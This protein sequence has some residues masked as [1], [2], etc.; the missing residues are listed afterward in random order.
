VRR[1]EAG[2]KSDRDFKSGKN[3]SR[4]ENSGA[5]FERGLARKE[6]DANY[7]QDGDLDSD[8]HKPMEEIADFSLPWLQLAL[9]IC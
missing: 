6:R 1:R 3:M 4:T 7:R 2:L 9:Y 5:G 8:D